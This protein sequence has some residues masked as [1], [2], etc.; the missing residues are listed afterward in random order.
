M[1]RHLRP[2]LAPTLA[3]ATLLLAP[4]APATA[5]PDRVPA[6]PVGV[7][8]GNGTSSIGLTWQQPAEGPRPDHFRV[9]EGS[10]VVARNTTTSATV[11]SLGYGTTHTYQVAAVT[12]RGVESP[13][14]APVT[15]SVS[16]SGAPPLC[17][18]P[19]GPVLRLG[20]I[21]VV[22]HVLAAGDPLG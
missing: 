5:G 16:V 18:P 13:L 21:A 2:L 10:V 7:T 17:E 12:A 9:Y 8:A 6:A 19:R 11:G 22:V 4:A 20:S 14:S 1:V 15:R 3:A